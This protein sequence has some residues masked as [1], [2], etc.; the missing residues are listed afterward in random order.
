M[1]WEAERKVV[2]GWV[3]VVVLV[4][5]CVALCLSVGWGSDAVECSDLSISDVRGWVH[6]RFL[7]RLKYSTC[8]SRCDVG[9]IFH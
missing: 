2:L 7:T 9:D 6:Q 3:G 1:A 4:L 8:S 5:S